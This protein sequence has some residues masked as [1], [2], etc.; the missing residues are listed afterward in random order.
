MI[1]LLKWFGC[2][3]P[4]RTKKAIPVEGIS[5]RWTVLGRDAGGPSSAVSWGE[6]WEEI[7][8]YEMTKLPR[9]W[10]SFSALPSTINFLPIVQFSY[11]DNRHEK[12]ILNALDPG[13]RAVAICSADAGKFV[14]FYCDINWT[15][16]SQALC[17]TLEEAQ[18]MVEAQYKS[19]GFRGLSGY[20]ESMESWLFPN[21]S[22][23][24]SRALIVECERVTDREGPD[25]FVTM[26]Y[27]EDG[28]HMVKE[29]FSFD[30]NACAHRGPA[31]YPQAIRNFFKPG[32]SIEVWYLK[33]NPVLRTYSD[34]FSESSR[35]GLC[36]FL[37]HTRC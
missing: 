25:Y 27:G 34:L 6:R 33:D 30:Q 19:I 1:F 14:V 8:D 31:G 17:E 2:L 26:V 11:I 7:P 37:A 35:Y 15:M 29:K 20:I 12:G 5:S 28:V 21:E 10:Q 22:V 23:V 13:V 16:L 36:N 32:E 4:G 3:F 18:A 9:P 24:V